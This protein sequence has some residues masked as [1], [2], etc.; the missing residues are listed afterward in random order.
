MSHKMPYVVVT[1]S[2]Y[3]SEVIQVKRTFDAQLSREAFR[4]IDSPS[5]GADPMTAALCCSSAAEIVM[6]RK[7]RR[8]LA[9][10]LSGT[11]TRAILDALEKEDTEMGYP[12]I[13]EGDPE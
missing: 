11:I 8:E 9:E 5:E 12:I 4:P 3:P 7:S 10:M 2:R 6:V 13:R 1:L